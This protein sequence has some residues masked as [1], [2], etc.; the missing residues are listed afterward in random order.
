MAGF[1][2]NDVHDR[3][4]DALAFIQRPVTVGLISVRQAITASSFL[5][6]IAFCVTPSH[7]RSTTILLITALAVTIYSIFAQRFPILKGVYTALLCCAPLSYGAAVGS[8]RFADTVFGALVLFICGREIYLDIRDIEGDRRFGL[9]TV[10]VFIGIPAARKV[11]VM[12]M[13]AGGLSILVIVRSTIGYLAA[14][15]SL[16]LL[17]LVLTWP[18]IE[19]QRR[20]QLTRFPM[21]L[22]AFA[23]A[24]TVWTG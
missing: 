8:G 18:G 15:G 1:I 14:G 13:I 23:L 21:L 12:L 2:L 3:P 20:L 19:L 4:K 5:F 6:I 24:S 22:G 10:P 17:G 11:A 16:V 7:G 9:T